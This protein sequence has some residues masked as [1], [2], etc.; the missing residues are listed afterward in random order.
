MSLIRPLT[1]R[2]LQR[3]IRIHGLQCDLF[4]NSRFLFDWEGL[5]YQFYVKEQKLLLER[6]RVRMD[7]T[8]GP[9]EVHWKRRRLVEE[10]W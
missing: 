9:M 6:I 5:E 4:D 7:I 2:R 10:F 3:L 1:K 8:I